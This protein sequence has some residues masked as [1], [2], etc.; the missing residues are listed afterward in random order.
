MVRIQCLDQ[1][2]SVSKPSNVTVEQF[3]F[4]W[5]DLLA[6]PNG[7]RQRILDQHLRGCWYLNPLFKVYCQ[8]ATPEF[9]REA[10]NCQAAWFRRLDCQFPDHGWRS[11]MRVARNARNGKAEVEGVLIVNGFEIDPQD[12]AESAKILAAPARVTRRNE[13]VV[14]LEQRDWRV[15]GQIARREL[16]GHLVKASDTPI[17]INPAITVTGVYPNPIFYAEA[18]KR[19]GE[20]NCTLCRELT[21]RGTAQLARQADWAARMLVFLGTLVVN[22]RFYLPGR[23]PNQRVTKARL[24]NSPFGHPTVPPE[25]LGLSHNTATIPDQ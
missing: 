4:D 6:M 18:E 1:V 22:G 13:A 19:C 16:E 14:A 5:N 7:E 10:K 11:R 2:K 8:Q 21:N 9:L 12:W 15:L 17:F 25:Y 24:D 3:A 20:W 23:W